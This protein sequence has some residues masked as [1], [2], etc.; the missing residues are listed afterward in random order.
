MI[1]VEKARLKAALTMMSEMYVFTPATGTM[2]PMATN[3]R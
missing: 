2:S 1:Q 3:S